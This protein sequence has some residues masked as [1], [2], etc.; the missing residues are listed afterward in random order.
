MATRVRK[1]ARE[2]GS[3]PHQVLGILHALGFV[4]YKS[5]EDMLSDPI[6]RKVKRGF[7]SGVQ[8]V[9]VVMAGARKKK[10][11]DLESLSGANGD[12]MSGIVP[13]V[14]P[15]GRTTRTLPPKAPPKPPTAP[16]GT[17]PSSQEAISSLKRTLESER[18]IVNLARQQADADR[19]QLAARRAMLEAEEQSLQS[20]RDALDAEREA[21]ERQRAEL[22]E[23]TANATGASNL[24]RLQELLE[25][26]GLRGADEFER[27]IGAL[28][29]GRGLRDILWALRVDGQAQVDEALRERL[30]LVNGQVS[31][32]LR[33]S[34]AVVQVARDRADIGDLTQ[35]TTRLKTL[36]DSLLLRG[37]VRLRI[38]GG[39]PVWWRFLQG[40]L[41]PRIRCSFHA[42]QV[43]EVNAA[44]DDVLQADVVVVW[45]VEVA[46]DASLVYQ[47][48]G[49]PIVYSENHTLK[50][51]ME[52]MEAYLGL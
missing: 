26:R 22:L 5:P 2:L 40:G 44:Q 4:R 45:G 33:R 10:A 13:G 50:G 32:S 52:D 46:S 14:T 30:L 21:L 31:E 47:Q 42:A 36:G 25:A 7:A 49:V 17:P 6:I 51:L 1:L 3:T 12:V 38:V 9:D 11:A 16:S 24:P 28:C 48:S 20:L 27:A 37:L 35:L 19:E 23:L 34:G 18:A 39:K 41:D 8:P 29:A 15:M 43:R